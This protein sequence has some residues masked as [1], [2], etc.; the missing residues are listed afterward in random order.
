MS[1]EMEIARD[2]VDDCSA[3]YYAALS[4]IQG[5]QSVSVYLLMALAGI[6]KV[7][8]IIHYVVYPNVIPIPIDPML[9]KTPSDVNH[10]HPGHIDHIQAQDVAWC[11]M[12]RYVH[13][14]VQLKKK[15]RVSAN[16][17]GTLL[18]RVL[19]SMITSD[20]FWYCMNV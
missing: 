16:Y 3:L 12:H 19:T 1:R 9:V 4:I 20:D 8:S 11:P 15:T 10:V 2:F 5:L 14:Y 13:V 18:T 17:E 7:S 6:R